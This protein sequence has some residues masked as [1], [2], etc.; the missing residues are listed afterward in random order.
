MGES[1]D[2]ANESRAAIEALPYLFV[3]L[4]AGSQCENPLLD[5]PRFPLDR[6][7]RSRDLSPLDDAGNESGTSSD[8]A[9]DLFE[10]DTFITHHEDPP[11]DR[12]EHLGHPFS[13][14]AP[15]TTGAR[16]PSERCVS[17]HGGTRR[18]KPGACGDSLLAMRVS[19]LDLGSNSFRLL[20][21]D[22]A[23]DGAIHP[24][25]RAREFIHLGSEVA[26]TGFLAD[27]VIER[28]VGAV[29]HLAGLGIRAGAERSMAVATSAIRDASNGTEVVARLQEA[30]GIPVRVIDGQEEARLGF[31]GVASSIALPTGPHLVLD[32]GGGSLE[33]AVGSGATLLWAESTELGVSR[34]WAEF[35]TGDPLSDRDIDRLEKRVRST[36]E[37]IVPQVRRLDPQWCVSIGGPSRALIQ[38][39]LQTGATWQPATLNQ[40]WVTAADLRDLRDR[41]VSLPLEERL[42]MPGMKPSR[43]EQ[44]PTAAVIVATVLDLL[45]VDRTVVSYWG[46]REGAILDAYGDA[47]LAFGQQLRLASVSRMERRFSPH[48]VHNAHVGGLAASLFDQLS[49]V[50]Q[51]D[52]AAADL[53]AAA[54]RL[55]TIG[56]GVGFRGH[57]RHGAY[58]IENSELR[59]F[60]PSEIAVLASIVRFHRRGI[61][62]SNY[63]PFET[64]DAEQQRCVRGLAAIL[65]L[66]DAAD[67]GLDQSVAGI[68]LKVSNGDVV[69]SFRG[70]D[71]ELRRDW[72][73]SA[74]AAF[75]QVFDIGL[76]FVGVRVIDSF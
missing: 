48:A 71:P 11:L 44:I 3:A 63:P 49:E 30:A 57:H 12:S 16:L 75:H 15:N 5:S 47:A 7:S 37:P 52:P 73:E 76:S 25:L 55:H 64:L 70:A 22:V 33:L 35:V 13:P 46:L 68:D 50:H 38:M 17:L 8:P 10:S 2:L 54:A 1:L 56:I 28:A 59:G 65:H 24:V 43:A 66:A 32:L 19:I 6:Q 41:L 51:L 26:A 42:A 18:P 20:V 62:G 60:E 67:R 23:A 34:L 4:A 40:A 53:L 31:L 29:G 14:P 74:E 21:A 45:E 39:V 36:L 27:D 72:V 61:V 69:A 58:L 9:G